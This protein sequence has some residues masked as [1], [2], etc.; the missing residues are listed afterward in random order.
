MTNVNNTFLYLFYEK[1]HTVSTSQN[2][3][4]AFLFFIEEKNCDVYI[5]KS[6]DKSEWSELFPLKLMIY[7]I[8]RVIVNAEYNS[9]FDHLK[10][11]LTTYFIRYHS[12]YSEVTWCR[13]KKQAED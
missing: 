2:H 13:V 11:K 1:M 10:K 7:I 12:H 4:C 6:T 8:M 3:F 5:D 9:S